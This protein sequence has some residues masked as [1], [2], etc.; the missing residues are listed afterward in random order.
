MAERIETKNTSDIKKHKIMVRKN[1]L[2]IDHSC[3]EVD[4][5][6]LECP[7]CLEMIPT[8]HL[9]STQCNH[10]YCNKCLKSI[11]TH[12]Q[13]SITCSLCRTPV[14][15][16]HYNDYDIMLDITDLLAEKFKPV[17]YSKEYSEILERL[18]TLQALATYC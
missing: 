12:S 2:Y 4:L 10:S 18:Y 11:I 16:Y 14:T 1:R 7:I 6:S 13:H 3:Y 15:K 8:T 5:S 17:F 9:I